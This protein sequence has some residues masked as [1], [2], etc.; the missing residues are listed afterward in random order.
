MNNPSPQDAFLRELI[1][2]LERKAY[3][4]ELI[5]G[6]PDDPL[7]SKFGGKPYF[8]DNEDW[9]ICSRCQNAMHFICQ[10]DLRQCSAADLP[11]DHFGLISFFYCWK[12]YPFETGAPGW[13][14]SYHER[15]AL[16]KYRA[17][18][19]PA[20]NENRNLLAKLISPPAKLTVPCTVK[21]IEAIS[22]PEY[23]E[24]EG[25]VPETSRLMLDDL[26]AVDQYYD[27]LE[28]IEARGADDCLT[29]V[30]GYGAWIQGKPELLCH[31]CGSELQLLVQI[32]SEKHAG[33]MFGDGGAIY[34][35]YCREHPDVLL[36]ESQCY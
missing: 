21:L 34:I 26:D 10:L 23:E 9:P 4:A 28:E 6:E 29:Q 27:L 36:M 18:E 16:E 12:C 33:I 5:A 2:P 31:E 1:A 19:M 8:E 13:M 17:L 22:I 30:G 32:G 35:T 3:R 14:F 7:A 11:A 15:P 20:K 25:L 24:F